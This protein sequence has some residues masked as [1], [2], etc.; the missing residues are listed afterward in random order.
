MPEGVVYP[1]W[2]NDNGGLTGDNNIELLINPDGM[3][4][5][6]TT[7]ALGKLVA[8]GI[9]EEGAFR[10]G[11]SPGDVGGSESKMSGVLTG[12]LDGAAMTGWLRVSSRDASLVRKAPV[13]LKKR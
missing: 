6:Q 1:S 4:K 8:V 9:A 3:V 10:L 7:G 2:K 11:L 13:S 12:K 5:G